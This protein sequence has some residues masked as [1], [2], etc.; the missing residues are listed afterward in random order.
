MP[1][2]RH[3]GP[4][5]IPAKA[6][7]HPGGCNA[8]P[9]RCHSRRPPSFLRKRE[10][11]GGAQPPFLPY[12]HSCPHRHSRESGNPSGGLQRYSCPLS[13]P[14]PTVIPAKAGIQEL[15]PPPFPGM[16]ESIA[17]VSTGLGLLAKFLDSR[18]RGNDGGAGVAPPDGY[19]GGAGVTLRRRNDV[20]TG[21]G[22]G[23]GV[24]LRRRNDVV[25]G[26]GG[27]A[28]VTL[29]RRNDVVTGNGGGAGVTLRRRNDVVTGY[30]GGAG[31]TRPAGM[32]VGQV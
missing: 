18:F 12:R 9:V 30:D 26:N 21:Y 3:S 11:I 23:A 32:T 24:T 13:F 16:R 5:V 7:I 28:G 31:M 4:A 20:V 17:S 1:A 27:G 19:D 25:T 2:H 10:S 8:I 14:P 29:R 22:G 15:P 6:G